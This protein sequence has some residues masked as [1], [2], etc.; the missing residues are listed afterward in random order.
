MDFSLFDR[1]SG[2]IRTQEGE[3]TAFAK[4]VASNEVLGLAMGFEFSNQMLSLAESVAL[5]PSSV[6]E[7]G[8]FSPDFGL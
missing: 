3:I 5:I 6:F 1:Q 2:V 4:R 7:K 8:V